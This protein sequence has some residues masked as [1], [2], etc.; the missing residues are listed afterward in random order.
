[1]R[2]PL[3]LL[4]L[5]GVS[6]FV[7]SQADSTA[8]Q[9]KDTIW[10]KGGVYNLNFSQ[11]GL[12]NWVGGGESSIALGSILDVFANYKKGNSSWNN[13]LTFAY[14]ISRVG[15]GDELFK[16]SD[17]QLIFI[18]KYGQKIN[19]NWYGSA[20]LDFRSQIAPGFTFATDTV[21]GQPVE[22]RDNV[23]SRFAAPAFALVSIG[24]EYKKGGLYSVVSPAAG[25]ITI[26]ADDELAAQGLF[27][28]D[29][30]DNVRFEFGA[31]VKAVYK[32]K[33]I[34]KNVDFSTSLTLF[35]AYTSFIKEIDVNG[36]ISLVF[37]VNK[38]LNAAFTGQVI[39]DEDVDITR[40]D[41][42]IGPGIQL[43]N[44]ISIGF[45]YKFNK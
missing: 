33:E 45:F 19:D 36:E 35:S 8:T 16:K 11:V 22:V 20:V 5:L 18:S 25:K 24:A 39:Y 17:D 32:K 26:V 1:M 23:I 40:S 3:L 2:N 28:V 37:K 14:G 4:C 12:R 7:F 13:S 21:D 44:T 6:T 9:K 41:G 38:Y 42:T 29:T 34:L 31:S 43:K 10:T 15:G 30:N 27:G